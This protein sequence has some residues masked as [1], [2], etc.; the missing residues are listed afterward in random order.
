M[1]NRE[2]YAEQ[3]LD[4]AVT[5]HSIAV[6]KKGKLHKCNELDCRDCIFSRVECSEPSC[7]EKTK[8]WSEQ[9]YVEPP[10]DWSKVPVDTKVFVRDCDSAYWNHRY[11]AKFED[12][13][14]FTWANGTTFFTAKGFDDVTWW[15]QGKLAEDT[16]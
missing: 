9:E 5:G 3:I 8:K 13:K 7:K 2:K 11:F 14:I 10:V 6:D 1:T 4:I 16:V 12:G 15:N